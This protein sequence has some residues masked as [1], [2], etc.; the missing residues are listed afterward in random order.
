M[1]LGFS[2]HAAFASTA[3]TTCRP[4]DPPRSA[5]PLSAVIGEK[6]RRCGES[7]G[8]RPSFLRSKAA[9]I[10]I[11]VASCGT[12]GAQMIPRLRQHAEARDVSILR[13]WRR[14]IAANELV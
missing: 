5:L 10:K 14:R 9:R 1:T 8:D 2:N 6:S 7:G 4:I 12:C 13:Q 3:S 11:E